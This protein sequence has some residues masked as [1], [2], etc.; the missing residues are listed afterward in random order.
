MKK[1]M[2]ITGGSSGIGKYCC[3][4]FNKLGYEV[5]TGARS[6]DKMKDLQQVGIKTHYLDLNDDDSI[7][8]FVMFIKKETTHVD[9]LINNAGYGSFGALEDVSINEAKR[10]FEVN[11]F[12]L[13]AITQALLPLMRIQKQGQI[14]NISS[15]A[16]RVYTPLGGWYYASKHA[17]EALS[18][19]LR[20]E[21]K[22]F[23]IDVI[24]I[25]PGGTQTN[26]QATMAEQMMKATPQDSPYYE[27]ALNYQSFDQ[28]LPIKNAQVE[29][30]ALLI[31]KALK[32]KRPKAR[33]LFAFS[34]K[35]M[36]FLV[37]KLPTKI[38]DWG[39]NKMMKK[40]KNK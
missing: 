40:F 38:T 12:G 8:A 39:I 10:Q 24:V 5:I 6:I 26:W 16:G 31:N 17:L 15:I 33:Y 11:V 1:V 32:A 4:Y 21:L 37:R 9:V 14:I 7:K 36:V 23:G 25:E 19:V 13:M 18:D 29:D 28:D 30:I 2:V 27:M 20:L 35:L 3:T 22:E 34:D